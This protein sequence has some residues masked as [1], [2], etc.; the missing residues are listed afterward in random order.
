MASKEEGRDSQ[1][2]GPSLILGLVGAV[3]VLLLLGAGIW[4]VSKIVS[5]IR[6]NREDTQ[7]ETVAEEE[8]EEEEKTDEEKKEDEEKTDEE[9]KDEDAAD[10]ED[11]TDEEDTDDTSDGDINGDGVTD[12]KDKKDAEDASE[13]A[14]EAIAG[15][16]VANDYKKG[17]IN[18]NSYKVVWEDTLWEIAEA[19]YGSGFEW[20]KILNANKDK[21]GFLPNGSQAL[22]F[23]GQVLELPE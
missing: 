17:D 3:F 8:K 18:G 2:L 11:K 19:R 1:S 10:E 4:G 20:T 12:E 13:K 7:E 6:E 21:V 23:P 9:K 22:I 16:W 5:K 14:S 15:M